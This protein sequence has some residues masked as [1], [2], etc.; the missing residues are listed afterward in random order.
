MPWP[1]ANW[2]LHTP[3]DAPRA[4]SMGSMVP[5]VP[6]PKGGGLRGSWCDL[7]ERKVAGGCYTARAGMGRMEGKKGEGEVVSLV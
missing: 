5:G 1:H 6:G 3:K 4:G 7:S 2:K